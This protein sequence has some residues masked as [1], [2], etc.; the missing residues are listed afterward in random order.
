MA[1]PITPRVGGT[2][3][4]ARRDGKVDKDLA[5]LTT[6][7]YVV[8]G[9]VRIGCR[10]GYEVKQMVEMSVRFYWT[11]SHVQIYPALRRL[12]E[13]GLLEGKDDPRG[14]RNRRVYDITMAGERALSDWLLTAADIPFELRDLGMGKLF[15]AD[16]LDES[17][18][19]VL[20]ASVRERSEQRLAVLR[21]SGL[22]AGAAGDGSN[23]YPFLTRK[24]GIALHQATVD[25]C[26]EFERDL[27]RRK[28]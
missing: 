3:T 21:T 24:L 13:H 28:P 17:S 5:D 15:F 27:L 6:Q 26:N 4:V 1:K 23:R 8:L 10:T 19:R 22:A 25:A 12:E 11:I 9:M 2:R 14:R 20:L 16:A 18:A 7:D